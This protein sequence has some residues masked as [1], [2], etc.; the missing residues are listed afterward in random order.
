MNCVPL[1]Q[2]YEA[3]QILLAFKTGL[4][5]VINS[6]LVNDYKSIRI[7]KTKK[8]NMY[9]EGMHSKETKT[10]KNKKPNSNYKHNKVLPSRKSFL[11][12]MLFP[13]LNRLQLLEQSC[14]LGHIICICKYWQSLG[15]DIKLYWLQCWNDLVLRHRHGICFIVRSL[16]W[17]LSEKHRHGSLFKVG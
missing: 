4:C 17:I 6:I 2:F 5:N 8:E 16:S 9:L 14:H 12:T 13:Q 7:H 10:K 15:T 11:A 1:D 3:M